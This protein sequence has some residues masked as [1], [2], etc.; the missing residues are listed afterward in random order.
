MTGRLPAM[1]C[2]IAIFACTRIPSRDSVSSGDYRLPPGT[3]RR[4]IEH[5][6]G[7][8]SYLIHLPPQADAGQPLPVILNFHG[9]GGN[10]RG[11]ESY[12]RMD[13]LADE[14]GFLVVY[15]D[16]TGRFEG[17]LLTWNAGGCCGYARDNSVDDVGFVRAVMQDV[18]RV[19]VVDGS[20]VYATG[21]SNGAM[22]AYR[23]AAEAP[24]LVAAIAPVAG[25][26]QMEAF[27]PGRPIP[28]LHIHSVDD[29]RALYNGGL[30]P[31]FP[32]TTN[33]VDHVAVETVLATWAENNGCGAE[34][35][36][37]EFHQ[38]QADEGEP[39]Q[40]A[41]RLVFPD[42]S[43]GGEVEHWRLTGAGHVWPGGEPGYLQT[44]LG[45][46]TGVIDANRE[47]WEFFGRFALPG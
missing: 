9:G 27:A 22:M 8:R 31:P 46:S 1:L 12:T 24:D 17:L 6:G 41:T 28:V 16:G 35:E 26:M 45:K 3:F 13:T 5:D 25:A 34:A 20:R 38:A 29:P 40:T 44:I 4:A 47:M 30:G 10:A 19:A 39:A 15:P 18:A 14:A 42:C 11:Q 2:L 32:L 7:E 43:L 36:V 33:R 23:V 37:V 21:L